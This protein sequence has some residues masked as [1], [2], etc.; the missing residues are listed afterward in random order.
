MERE[1]R[2]NEREGVERR[3]VEDA[4]GRGRRREGDVYLSHG[5]LWVDDVIW[6]T[7]QWGCQQLV[8]SATH[9]GGVCV[10]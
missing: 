8:N 4:E 5:G 6:C 7:V 2:R 9:G 3:R 10:T 1:G